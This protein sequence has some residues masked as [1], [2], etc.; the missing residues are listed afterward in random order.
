L[1]SQNLGKIADFKRKVHSRSQK[2]ENKELPPDK[3][4]LKKNI[5]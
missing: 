1:Y 4:F 2:S 5:N 3:D